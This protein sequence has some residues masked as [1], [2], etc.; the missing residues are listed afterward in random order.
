M[1][2]GGITTYEREFGAVFKMPADAKERLRTL[3]LQ[4]G[5]MVVLAAIQRRRKGERQ[6]EGNIDFGYGRYLRTGRIS[7]LFTRSY[8]SFDFMRESSFKGTPSLDA[9]KVMF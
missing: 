7:G 9:R 2:L 5:V 1:S 3:Q 8:K 4:T 6:I